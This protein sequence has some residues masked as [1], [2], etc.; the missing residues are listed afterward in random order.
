M[1]SSS[2]PGFSVV[3]VLVA[4]SLLSLVLLSLGGGATLA[5]SQMTKARQDLQYSADVQ[6]VGDSLIGVGWNQVTSGSSTIRGRSVAWTV[7]TL[8]VNSQKVTLVVQRRGQAN[9]G[10]VYSDTVALYLAKPQVQ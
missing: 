1:P 10:T 3:E 5:L 4:M 2:R 8:S 9:T 7:S 6:Q